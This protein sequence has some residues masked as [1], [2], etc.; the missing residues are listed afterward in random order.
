MPKKYEVFL[1][2]TFRDLS[3]YRASVMRGI[4]R[5]D[6]FSCDGMEKFTATPLS[7]IE[8]CLRRVEHC[9]IYVGV[10]G[11]FRGGCPNGSSMSFTEH[12]YE[13]A[14]ERNI[15]TLMFVTSEVFLIPANL[16]NSGPD[17]ER[18]EAFKDKVLENDVVDSFSKP[19]ELRSKVVEA[20][21]NWKDRQQ[22]RVNVN[23]D[24]G[25]YHIVVKGK[26]GIESRYVE[27]SQNTPFE[28][29]PNVDDWH[30]QWITIFQDDYPSPMVL[31][32]SSG[33]MPEHVS[34]LR[35]STATYKPN[36][37]GARATAE[38]DEPRFEEIKD[39]IYALLL[40]PGKVNYLTHSSSPVTQQVLLGEGAYTLWV[41]GEG[42]AEVIQL[43]DGS[44]SLGISTHCEPLVFEL[45]ESC[46]LL[47][48]VHGVLNLFQLEYGK[49]PTSYIE[50][51]ENQIIV[52][53]NDIIEWSSPTQDRSNTMTPSK[54]FRYIK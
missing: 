22:A 31:D 54:N 39:G 26:L 29:H 33:E 43:G 47:I 13:H 30:I 6:T 32:F 37:L 7:S 35:N 42:G 50:S 41:E 40:E 4:E 51:G 49:S 5:L 16:R 46:R 48:K 34:L 12:E 8:E 38:I 10:I 27:I 45:N 23:L 18:Q 44:K 36:F 17:Q 25:A 3:E 2:S 28:I 21:S 24:P 9:D 52:R 20:L 19:E 11:D 15:P 14:K 53:A 1:S